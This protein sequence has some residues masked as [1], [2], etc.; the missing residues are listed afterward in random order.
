MTTAV[1][2]LG[3]QAS[4]PGQNTV[5][6]TCVILL[7]LVST[8]VALPSESA[9]EVFTFA[10]IGVG[11][12]LIVATVIEGTS[13]VRT[14]VRVDMLIFW[15]LYGLTF[16]EFLFPQPGVNNMLSP[17]A[18]VSG[19]NAVL[20]GFAGIAIGR[21]LV[22]K[23]AGSRRRIA[24]IDLRAR[25]VFLLFVLATLLG[26]FHIFLAVNFDPLEVVR[27]MALPRFSQSWA[28]GR[29][30]DAA[31]LLYEL[32][33]VIYLIPPTA[34]LIYAR[35]QEYSVIQKVI[36]TIV[37]VF[38]FYFGF[39]S[40]TRSVFVTYVIT[41]VG[42]YAVAKPGFN[43]RQALLLGVPTLAILFVGTV[44]MLEFRT[45][46][47]SNFSSDTNSR[48][49]FFI[50]YNIVNVSRLT[51]VFPDSFEYLG[52]EIPYNAVIR[53]IPRVLWPSKPE[54][55][56]VSIETAL[57]ASGFVTLTCTFIGEAYVAGGLFAV[58]LMGAFFGAAAELWNRLGSNRSQFAQL[59][60]VS[61]FLPAALGMRSMLSMVPF[62]LPT[63][64]LW[65][66]GKLWLPRSSMLYSPSAVIRNKL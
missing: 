48:D 38:T 45:I 21:H 13:G 19:T 58:L 34:G 50:D 12:T 20:L 41:F 4:K 54:G 10:A 61:G 11:L 33:A 24:F 29:Y 43:L 37:L 8:S 5:L 39:A 47:L 16:L 53:P 55:L 60:Y 27:Q 44:Y 35:A 17:G 52:L 66:F 2:K 49:V 36:V 22:P 14:L 59:L 40:G 32:G 7:G 42:V 3:G 64:A 28:R 1:N 56:S 18:A 31:A 25:N 23:R 65:V 63:L 30:G 26:Y 57:G 15:V 51:E 62:M 46:G 9:V 6:S